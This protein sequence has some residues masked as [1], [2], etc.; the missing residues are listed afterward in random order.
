M[1]EGFPRE[2]QLPNYCGP[3][4][5][6]SVLKFWGK[7][8]QDQ[9]TIARCVYDPKLSATNGADLLLYARSTGLAAYSFNGSIP[10]LKILLA[11]GLPVI[12]LQDTDKRDRSGH[13]RVTI[14]FDE[15]KQQVIVFDP[16]DLDRTRMGYEEFAD[17]WARRGN[18]GLLVIPAEKDSFARKMNDLNP[19]V[20]LDL[21][22][23]YYRKGAYD[24]ADREIRAALFLEP[25]NS[26]AR[27]LFSR[28]EMMR[29]AAGTGS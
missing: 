6:S 5:L 22:Q 23:A 18:W 10:F 12:V 15:R 16:Y 25:A 27:E 20:H 29:G 19:V 17:L 21:A 24:E 2:K 9:K 28:I 7:S 3:A 4:A 14:G 26:C 13:F 1:L 11:K 8:E